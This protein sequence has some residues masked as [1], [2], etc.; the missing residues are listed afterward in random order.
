MQV[1]LYN[2][3]ND[4]FEHIASLLSDVYYSPQGYRKAQDEQRFQLMATDSNT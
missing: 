1:G 3:E 4:A 2:D